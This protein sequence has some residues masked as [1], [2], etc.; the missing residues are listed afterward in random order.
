MRRY[1]LN[2]SILTVCVLAVIV[3][4]VGCVSP[5]SYHTARTVDS[6]ETEILLAL[7]GSGST[8][9]FSDGVQVQHPSLHIRRGVADTIDLGLSAGS[10]G[11][12]LD[13]NFMLAE[14][15]EIAFSV[16]PYGG[17]AG[18]W[19]LFRDDGAAREDVVLATAQLGIFVDVAAADSV[20]LTLG[21]KPGVF[22]QMEWSG[23]G[24]SE[25]QRMRGYYVA[26]SAGM[27]IDL[28]NEMHLFPE[29]NVLWMDDIQ[30][31]DLPV[32]GVIITVGMGL[33]F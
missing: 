15:D 2:P 25:R 9:D 13:A 3:T 31:G 12:G 27:R 30:P 5:S 19:E 28:E 22:H 6:G 14:S 24:E 23:F 29:V 16:N 8:S 32:D 17:V 21:G 33:G 1:S 10:T 7:E 18:V 20:T 4:L 26:G 11:T